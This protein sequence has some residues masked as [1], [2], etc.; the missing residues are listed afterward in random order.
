ML[1][2]SGAVEGSVQIARPGRKRNTHRRGC[3]DQLTKKYRTG[4]RANNQ[5]DVRQEAR[6][7]A[8]SQ[9]YYIMRNTARNHHFVPRFYLSGFSDLNLQNEQLHVID[10]ENRR[11]FVTTPRKIASQR[12]FNR[13][14]I[15]G[16]PMDAIERQLAQI[17]G[18]VATVLRSIAENATLPEENTDI[19]YLIVF[20]AIL[21]ANNPQIRDRL[22]DRDRE[23]F[24][25]MMQSRVAS[26]ETY[27]SRLSDLGI[28]DQIGYEATR[29]FVESEHYTISIE[30][31]FGYYL[32]W[33]FASLHNAVLPFFN[34]MRWTLLIAEES[35][36]D[37]ICS[38]RPVFLFK[39]VDLMPYQQPR[40]KVTQ[41]GLLIPNETVPSVHYE[42]TM[43][44]NPRMALY[45]TTPENCFPIE[46]GDQMTVACINKRTIDAATRQIYCS[47]LD[48]K[49]LD[50]EVMKSGWDLVD[51]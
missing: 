22:I 7:L 41:A 24:R 43:P 8:D 37:F 2:T 9:N 39:I 46:Y 29:A 35:A 33:V 27:E 3:Q 11:H 50:N 26:R 49:F 31:P 34:V 1:F 15:Q 36:S 20:A 32:A 17:E 30:D 25:Q 47:N 12:D 14:N 18:R 28:E 51:E 42:L 6:C 38:D 16:Y 10:K 4:F 19:D 48:F 13:I 45:G 23:T 5:K 44:L 21:A 40:Y